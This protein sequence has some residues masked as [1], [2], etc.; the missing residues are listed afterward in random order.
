MRITKGV[1]QNLRQGG[2]SFGRWAADMEGQCAGGGL[3]GR[4]RTELDD[5]G[6]QGV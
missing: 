3:W 2:N 6:R 1:C 4:G 5:L